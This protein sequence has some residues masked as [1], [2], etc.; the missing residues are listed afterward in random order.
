MSIEFGQ[1]H[2]FLTDFDNYN[3]ALPIYAKS[4]FSESQVKILREAIGKSLE[5]PFASDRL[6]GDQEEFTSDNRFDPRIM[7]HMSRLVV[8]FVCP[9]II[10]SVMDGYCKPIYKDEIRL[11][12]YN[13]L[14]YHPK[15]GDNR[16]LP[17]LPP[18]IDGT[19]NI[20]T[21]NYQ[22]GGNID[23]EVFID[24]KPYS[25]STGDAIIFSA[26]NQ[27]HWRPKRKW[28]PDD[29]VEIVS[30]D[31]CPPHDWRLSGKE[32]PIDPARRP[33]EYQEYLQSLSNYPKFTS[34][35]DQYNQMGLEIGIAE[36]IHGVLK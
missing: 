27:V 24:G 3:L 10:E 9:E 14:E 20:V 28:S 11:A 7:T 34:A 6:P 29:F 23:W 35:W 36:N 5:R 2:K 17:S 25:L 30:F 4:P 12:H 31:Y 16:Y 21:F 32:N 1:M 33:K 8:E 26:I 15:Y 22:I 13:Y 19:E 18:H